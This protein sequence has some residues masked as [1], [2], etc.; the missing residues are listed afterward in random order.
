MQVWSHEDQP[1]NLRALLDQGS[2]AFFISERAAQLLR[3]KKH[4]VNVPV[5][6]IGSVS[7]GVVK[8]SVEI[9]FSSRV[10]AA[11]QFTIIA[12]VMKR[13]PNIPAMDSITRSQW[14]HFGDI[15][16]A[17]PGFSSVSEVDIILGADIYGNLLLDGLR[18]GPVGAP[19]AHNTVL[20]WILSGSVKKS[21]VGT[22]ISSFNA[23]LHQQ[24]TCCELSEVGEIPLTEYE[25]A[26]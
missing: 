19:V 10:F 7:A 9:Q 17:D 1:Y 12:Y 5:I 23:V 18:K 24:P 13:L 25:R 6:G 22:S 3:L 16:L 11:K 15:H 14:S 8:S 4:W 21:N 26:C 20:G 2:E